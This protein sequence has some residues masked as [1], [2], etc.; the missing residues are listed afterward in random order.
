MNKQ[1]NKHRTVY[2]SWETDGE[3]VDLPDKVDVPITLKDNEIANYL[4][5]KYGWLVKSFSF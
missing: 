3:S 2:V 1:K 5:D 4:S